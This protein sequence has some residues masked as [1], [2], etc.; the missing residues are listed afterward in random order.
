[1]K[2]RAGEKVKDPSKFVTELMDYIYAYY[3]KEIDKLKT[4]KGKAGREE[5]A[6]MCYHTSLIQIRARS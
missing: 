5:S 6:K 2:V 4:E 3:Q 1:M